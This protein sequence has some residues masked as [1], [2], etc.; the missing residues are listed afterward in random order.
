MSLISQRALKPTN[1]LFKFPSCKY[2]QYAYNKSCQCLWSF[3][4]RNGVQ[5]ITALCWQSLPEALKMEFSTWP[6]LASQKV[7]SWSCVIVEEVREHYSETLLPLRL[8][9][10][11]LL[12]REWIVSGFCSVWPITHPELLPSV[13]KSSRAAVHQS[14]P[15]YS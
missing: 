10:R 9:S 4:Y 13:A 12:Q 3:C 2:L 11:R 7:C 8:S 15:C 6:F 5:W 1:L 14:K